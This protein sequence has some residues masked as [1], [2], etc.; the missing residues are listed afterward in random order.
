MV[1]LA[2]GRGPRTESNDIYHR[3]ILIVL[4]LGLFF[5]TRRVRGMR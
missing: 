3:V 2:M 1:A 4:V 5:L